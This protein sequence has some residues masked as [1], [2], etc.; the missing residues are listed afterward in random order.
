M[1]R[2][3]NVAFV[4]VLVL[5]GSGIGA[6]VLHLPLLA[7]LWETSYGKAILVKIALL[8]AAMGLGAINLLRTTP[9]LAA[10]RE[11]SELGAPA[12]ALLRRLVGGE[13]V[14]VAVAVLAAAV[15]SSLA[16]PA[17]AL[18]KESQARRPRRPGPGRGG[19]ER[20]TATRSRCASR[21]TGPRSRTPSRSS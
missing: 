21:R 4:S 14:L 16:P 12:A 18:A 1:P 11:R 3:S 9:R 20:R 2:F 13:A 17:N 19:R 10:A 7:A 15:L 6:T 5:L 8:V